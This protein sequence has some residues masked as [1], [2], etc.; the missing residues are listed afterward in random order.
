MELIIFRKSYRRS[1][2]EIRNGDIE[3][4]EKKGFKGSSG[5][6]FETLLRS[7]ISLVLFYLTLF[8]SRSSSPPTARLFFLCWLRFSQI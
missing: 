7:D 2:E 1:W 4:I 8:F 3:F 6:I 5:I